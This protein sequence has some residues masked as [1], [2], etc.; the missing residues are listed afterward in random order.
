MSKFF[1]V[2]MMLPL[3]AACATSTGTAPARN[4]EMELLR[5]QNVD[6]RRKVAMQRGGVTA[7]GHHA[8][9]GAM[10]PPPAR[11]VRRG[12]PQHLAWL[13]QAPRGCA[14]GPLSVEFEN[15]TD[16]YVRILLDG[17]ELVVRGADGVMPHVP[18]RTSVFVCLHETGQHNISGIAY[19]AR[20]G[21]LRETERFSRGWIFGSTIRTARGRQHFLIDKSLLRFY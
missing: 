8:H 6:L 7:R 2:F 10:I 14:S 17:K 11:P 20:Y 18:P 12:P 3:F 1:M 9:H 15:R 16:F 5:Q 13:H 21:E 19:I 4:A